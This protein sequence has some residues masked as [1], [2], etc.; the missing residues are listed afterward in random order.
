MDELALKVEAL[1]QSALEMYENIGG[2]QKATTSHAATLWVL[3]GI[4]SEMLRQHPT[5][6][7][8]LRE[9]IK[10]LPAAAAAE[11]TCILD[12]IEADAAR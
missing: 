1:G 9:D 12:T 4:A 2:L 7:R 5:D 11:V 6:L 3:R 10:E 8:F